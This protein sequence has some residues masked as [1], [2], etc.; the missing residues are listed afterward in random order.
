MNAQRRAGAP[1][2]SRVSTTFCWGTMKALCWTNGREVEQRELAAFPPPGFRGEPIVQLA[3]FPPPGFGGQPIVHHC[4]IQ[5]IC[6][7]FL[8]NLNLLHKCIYYKLCNMTFPSRSHYR[9]VFFR[10]FYV[11]VVGVENPTIWSG[12]YVT[13][14]RHWMIIILRLGGF[15]TLGPPRPAFGFHWLQNKQ[16]R[17]GLQKSNWLLSIQ[18]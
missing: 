11:G 2:R 6:F 1:P 3:A 7:L 13:R 15:W 12:G 8:L 9:Q 14:R 5:Q 16:V 18:Q 4:S 10:R 17:R